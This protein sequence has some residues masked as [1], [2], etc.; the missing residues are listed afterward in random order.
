VGWSIQISMV[1]TA[2]GW[3][4]VEASFWPANLGARAMVTVVVKS[5]QGLWESIVFIWN[6][7]ERNG[8]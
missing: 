3:M 6:K 7:R 1:W 8:D 4:A 5:D 2:L